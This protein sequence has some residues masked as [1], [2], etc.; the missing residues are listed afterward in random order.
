MIDVVAARPGGPRPLRRPGVPGVAPDRS[1]ERPG[2]HQAGRGL[3]RRR[4]PP[5]HADD[6]LRRGRAGVGAGSAGRARTPFG[7]IGRTSSRIYATDAGPRDRIARRRPRP[8]AVL[9]RQRSGDPD[10]ATAPPAPAGVPRDTV[11][12]MAPSDQ[13]RL[14]LVEDVPQVAQYVRGLLNAQTQVKLIDVDRRRLPGAGPG[15]RAATRRRGRRWAAPGTPAR[16]AAG[17]AAPRR[18]GRRAGHRPHGAAA[19]ARSG[20]RE[21]DP[22]RPVDAVQRLRPDQPGHQ[23]QQGR[24]RRGRARSEPDHR[25]VRAEGRRRQDDDRL[26]PRGRRVRARRSNRARRREHPVR[27]PSRPSSTCPTRRR[28]CSTC[29]PTRSSSRT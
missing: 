12:G 8:L 19:P 25:G 29:R 16:H 10:P 28:R 17:Q 14:L 2:G 26:Q 13:V 18:R 9:A 21:R 7:S 23:R 27:G 5:R 22:R 4:Q 1:A 15:H 6:D 11:S 3:V 20:P 24:G